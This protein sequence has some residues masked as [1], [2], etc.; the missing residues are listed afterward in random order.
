MRLFS[1]IK[2]FHIHRKSSNDAKAPDALNEPD[3][4][5]KHK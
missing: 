3:R 2:K 5:S 4:V 1:P